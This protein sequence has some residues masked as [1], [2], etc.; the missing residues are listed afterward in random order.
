MVKANIQTIK[1]VAADLVASMIGW[2]LFNIYRYEAIGHLSFPSLNSFLTYRKVIEGQLLSPLLW[3]GLF[4]LSGYYNQPF[5]K[6]RLEELKTT[7]SSVFIGSLFFF[8]GVILDDT[9]VQPSDFFSLITCLFL[10]EFLLVYFLRYCITSHATKLIHGGKW[11]FNTL[12]IG[13]GEH[14]SKLTL[15]IQTK[16]QQLG[17]ILIGHIE[18]GYEEKISQDLPILGTMENLDQI[19][20]QYQIERFIFAPDIRTPEAI[21]KTIYKLYPYGFAIRMQADLQDI[22]LGKV[23]MRSLYETP[24]LDISKGK[25]SESQICCKRTGDIILSIIALLLLS[26][27]YLILALFVKIDSKGPVLYKQERIGKFGRPFQIIKFRTMYTDA[28]TNGPSLSAC[29]DPRITPMGQFLRKYRL[30]EI[31]QFWNVLKGDMS[32]V[33]PRPERACYI[34]QIAKEAPYYC[35]IHQVRP[36]ITSW[37]MVKYGYAT[38]VS[39]MIERLQYDILYL[40]NI[41]LAVDCKILIYT[42]RTVLTGRGI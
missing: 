10:C 40:E 4:F 39:Q 17:Y 9:P 28:E 32:L 30:D 27:L 16:K 25:M 22:L 24:M 35:L 5:Q 33:G 1:Y 20:R 7:F 19:V 34:E 42:V 31:T 2:L 23:K 41:S 11:G 14:A 12:I 29:G 8:F 3:L 36:G 38:N 6:S 21:F 18:T 13:A 15:D 26:P 37:G